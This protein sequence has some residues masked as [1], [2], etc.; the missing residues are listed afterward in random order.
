MEFPDIVSELLSR[1]F[2][3]D[4]CVYWKEVSPFGE[5]IY[6]YHDSVVAIRL[7]EL[8]DEVHAY[9][10][11]S[12]VRRRQRLKVTGREAFVGFCSQAVIAA[13]QL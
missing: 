8:D 7:W 1:P 5:R 11:P 13:H 3:G 9:R 10:M 12:G 4:G 2:H 6:Y